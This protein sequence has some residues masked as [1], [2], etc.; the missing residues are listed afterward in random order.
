MCAGYFGHNF[1]LSTEVA[2]ST[3]VSSHC[4]TQRFSQAHILKKYVSM[5]SMPAKIDIYE[6]FESHSSKSV[7][8]ARKLPSVYRFLILTQV[9]I[10]M[11]PSPPMSPCFNAICLHHTR[12]STKSR[13]FCAGKRCLLRTNSSV[14]ERSRLCTQSSGN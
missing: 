3:L 13:R 11:L 4:C 9:L 2:R 12:A 5:R 7:Q 1:R 10:E 6:A 14:P 8:N